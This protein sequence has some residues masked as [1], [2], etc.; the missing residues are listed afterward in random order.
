ME[1][2]N[3]CRGHEKENTEIPESGFIHVM[4]RGVRAPAPPKSSTRYMND[5]RR[6]A[7][8]I[9]LEQS[10]KKHALLSYAKHRRIPAVLSGKVLK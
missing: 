7:A 9:P 4:Y 8:A 3:E 2:T 5:E 1:N 6:D 10:L